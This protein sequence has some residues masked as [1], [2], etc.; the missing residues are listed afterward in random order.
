MRLEEAIFSSPTGYAGH[1]SSL[2]S[3]QLWVVSRDNL[4]QYRVLWRPTGHI[5]VDTFYPVQKQLRASIGWEA[6]EHFNFGIAAP[7]KSEPA[8]AVIPHPQNADLTR[9]LE[10]VKQHV[11]LEHEMRPSALLAAALNELT[12]IITAAKGQPVFAKRPSDKDFEPRAGVETTSAYGG[13]CVR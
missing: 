3:R 11:T 10:L 2:N 13:R 6:L 9:R 5:A 8:P 4:A 7:P 1:V 12:Y